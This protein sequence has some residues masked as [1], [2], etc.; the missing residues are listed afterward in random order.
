MESVVLS[1]LPHPNSVSVSVSA[2][3]PGGSRADA[4]IGI[5]NA[6]GAGASDAPVI[7][8][9]APIACRRQV[10]TQKEL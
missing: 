2:A 9:R 3:V 8:R 7:K 10:I 6:A 4:G 1:R 5:G